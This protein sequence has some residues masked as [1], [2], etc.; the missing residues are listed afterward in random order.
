VHQGEQAAQHGHGEQYEGRFQQR[1]AG[2]IGLGCI[3]A[4]QTDRVIDGLPQQLRDGEL[5]NRRAERRYDR[6][7]KLEP[8]AGCDPDDAPKNAEIPGDAVAGSGCNAA[9]WASAH[10]LPS[11]GGRRRPSFPVVGTGHDFGAL[12]LSKGGRPLPLDGSYIVRPRGQVES[13]F[14]GPV[15]RG[16]DRTQTGGKIF[17]FKAFL[18]FRCRTGPQR[19]AERHAVS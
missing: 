19:T 5:E 18:S 6:D 14:R 13:D 3:P 4:E 10:A 17:G 9:V 12:W 1:P 7:R 15:T 2:Q 16:A 11:I 8:V